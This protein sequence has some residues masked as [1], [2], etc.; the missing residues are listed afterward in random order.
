MSLYLSSQE[1]QKV[2][3][4]YLV[5]ANEYYQE[6]YYNNA[7]ISYQKAI[8]TDSKKSD[9][10][11][12]LAEIYILKN[13]L[14]NAELILK[15]G[16]KN[17]KDDDSI[18]L[19]LGDLLSKQT[20]YDETL[21]AYLQI[22]NK[23]ASTKIAITYYQLNQANQALTTLNELTEN[24]YSEEYYYLKSL[25]F[26]FSDPQE[27][28]K[29]LETG[30]F[31]NELSIK[32][33]TLK[34]LLKNENSEYN[35]LLLS[36][37]IISQ[38]FPSLATNTLQQITADNPQYRDAYLILGKA[39]FE[40]NSLNEAEIAW[41]KAI[42]IDPTSGETH[43]LLSQLYYAQNNFQNARI[44]AEKAF[45]LEPINYRF[46]SFLAKI[47]D[48]EQNCDLKIQ[49]QEKTVN[50]LASWQDPQTLQENQIILINYYLN[51]NEITEA[52]SLAEKLNNSQNSLEKE[53]IIK[54][55]YLWIK[56]LKEKDETLISLYQNYL[57]KFPNSASGHYHYGKILEEFGNLTESKKEIERA[58]EL[59][60]LNNPI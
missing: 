17:V 38:G 49:T 30:N 18:Y 19:A 23:E 24:N 43:F 14:Q 6:K 27:A 16:A 11:L 13:N 57:Q 1:K 56:W 2:Y 40:V 53:K 26:I 28:L 32:T 58:F 37:E 47:Y 59:E 9:S 60:E 54:D 50:D 22:K 20:R 45:N 48:K 5:Q 31:T 34:T 51:C 55:L 8:V 7:L 29:I 21:N 33:S 15:E 10:Y 25:Y 3:D 42:E 39:Y 46:S 35:K 36:R 41:Q 12:K 4:K 52:F 44:E